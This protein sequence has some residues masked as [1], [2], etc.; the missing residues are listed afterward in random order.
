MRSAPV[1]LQELRR[2]RGHEARE[3]L[4][5]RAAGDGDDAFKHGEAVAR[6]WAVV[7][8]EHYWHQA[9]RGQSFQGHDDLGLWVGDRA[10]E[11]RGGIYER[12]CLVG[13]VNSLAAL[14]V[15]VLAQV[16]TCWHAGG[17]CLRRSGEA[18]GASRRLWR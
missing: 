2:L 4:L 5:E 18:A 10:G 13:G 12:I 15:L 11:F 17:R 3:R 16:Y 8:E 6:V 1:A 9:Y 14:L 7:E